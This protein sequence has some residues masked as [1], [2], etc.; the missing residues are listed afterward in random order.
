VVPKLNGDSL[1]KAKALLRAAHCK[2]GKVSEPK[3]RKHHRLGKM[4]VSR[5]AP[6]KGAKRTAGTKIAIKLGLA[7]KPKHRRRHHSRA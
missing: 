6:G 5:S 7:P 2:L 3:A 4:A 1:A